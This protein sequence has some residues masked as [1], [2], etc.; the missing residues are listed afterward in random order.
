MAEAAG[1]PTSMTEKLEAEA[2]DHGGD[3]GGE[4]GAHE[5]VD[6]EVQADEADADGKAGLQALA[7]AGTE[8]HAED[9]K[10]DRHDDGDA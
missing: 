1:Q 8:E 9:R 6:D 4:V 10:N 3:A 7:K 5:L 2:L